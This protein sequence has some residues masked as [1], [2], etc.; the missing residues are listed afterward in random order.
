MINYFLIN[1]HILSSRKNSF[2]PTFSVTE[3]K[4]GG[5]PR[6]L[7]RHVCIGIVDRAAT[8]PS[9]HEGESGPTVIGLLSG[10][11]FWPSFGH[12]SCGRPRLRPAA[13]RLVGWGGG[14]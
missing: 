6:I 1:C 8:G 2:T 14:A 12:V 7:D 13:V 4:E 11:A 10:R 5:G 9:E 3:W